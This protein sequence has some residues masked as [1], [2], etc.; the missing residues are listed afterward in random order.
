MIAFRIVGDALKGVNTA[1]LDSQLLVPQVLNGFHESICDVAS[2]N[3]FRGPSGSFGVLECCYGSM[4]SGL[5]TP[6]SG[7]DAEKY[8]EPGQNLEDVTYPF[9]RCRP[10]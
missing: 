1:K 8:R 10:T 2:L 6:P 9:T 4:L 5:N 3:K 7:D